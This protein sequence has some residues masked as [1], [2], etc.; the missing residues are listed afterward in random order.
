MLGWFKMRKD[1]LRYL[2][3]TIEEEKSCHHQNR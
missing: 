3:L 2:T 1:Q